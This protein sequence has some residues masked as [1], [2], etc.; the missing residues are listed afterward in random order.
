MD[1]HVLKEKKW[2][3]WD[4]FVELLKCHRQDPAHS[5]MCLAPGGGAEETHANK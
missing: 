5:F 3:G 4:R 1:K 2:L